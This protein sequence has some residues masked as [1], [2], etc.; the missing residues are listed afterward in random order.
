LEKL[1]TDTGND[2]SKKLASNATA[3]SRTAMVASSVRTALDQEIQ[4]LTALKDLI[5]PESMEN[6]NGFAE[7]AQKDAL[8]H[9]GI[10]DALR[11]K[12]ATEH[13]VTAKE[14]APLVD[15]VDA[16]VE[17][18]AESPF[19]RKKI[20]FSLTECPFAKD[21]KEEQIVFLNNLVTVNDFHVA[22]DTPEITF[23]AYFGD[24]TPDLTV[25]AI[26]SVIELLGQTVWERFYG[27]HKVTA[28]D[29]VPKWLANK[30]IASC[31]I[32][33]DTLLETSGDVKADVSKKKVS[34]L[35]RLTKGLKDRKVTGGVKKNTTKA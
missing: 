19:Y 21:L 27:E 22:N 17:V 14:E 24:M 8:H 12:L 13:G 18:V 35:A 26:S 20:D 11:A 16:T 30:A 7:R 34:T 2:Y 10:M 5:D 32:R 28:T 4:K 9:T 25:T 33:L 31:L 23:G 3:S 15:A 6:A 1:V 29:I